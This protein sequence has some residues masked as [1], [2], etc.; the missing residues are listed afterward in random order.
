MR[1][2]SRYVFRQAL[3]ALLLIL[4]SLSGI[5][6]I[7][8]AL[9]QLDVVTS[10]GQD[11]TTLVLMTSLAVP[12]LMAI[13]APFSFLIAALHTLNRMNNDSELIVVTASGGR[14][15]TIIR[16]L[17]VLAIGLAVVLS[18]IAHVVQ[19]WSMRL[20]REYIIEVRTDL[21]TS[22]IQPGRFST[23][24]KGLTLHVRERAKNGEILGL[25]VHDARN[26]KEEQTYL[27]GRGVIVDQE[28]G[29][30]LVMSDGHIL[31]RAGVKEAP[32]IVAFDNYAISLD[33]FTAEGGQGRDPK[34]RALSTL[35]LFFPPQDNDY[36]KRNPGLFRAELHERIAAPLYPIAFVF[37]LAALVGQAQSTRTSRIQSVAAAFVL[38]AGCRLLGLAL[39]NLSASTALAVPLVY[40]LPVFAILLSLMYMKRSNVPRPPS[41]L[42]RTG[43]QL[44]ETIMARLPWLT[45]SKDAPAQ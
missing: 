34:P 2:F 13:I 16:P 38:A 39:N 14:I 26:N 36:F 44:I 27:A 20:L 33:Q 24:E 43:S 17:L 42:W 8:L 41:F 21:L 18:F 25:M 12:N 10:Q 40:G 29:A 4:G 9:R 35:D 5:V 11:T 6:W 15:S 23:P 37:I 7:A 22:V 3:S 28:D 32:Q 19:P 45:A 30:Y 31:R 1:I